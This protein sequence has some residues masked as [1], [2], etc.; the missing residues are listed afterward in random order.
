MAPMFLI[1]NVEMVV[2][3]LRAGITACLP[4]QNYRGPEKFEQAMLDIKNQSGDL[5]FG[6]NLIANRSNIQ[7]GEQLEVVLN[8]APKFIITSLGSPKEIITAAHKKNIMVFCDVVDRTHAEKVQSLG[9][10]AVVA[11]NSGA[12]GHAGNIPASILVP[13]LK[14]HLSLPVLSAGGVACGKSLHS[15]LALG[16]DGV[17]IG[18][19]FIA[20]IE[21]PVS[22]DYK[23]AIIDYGASDVVRTTKLSGTPCTVINTPYVKR[24]GTEQNSIERLLNNNRSLKKFTKMLTLYKGMKGLEKAAFSTTYKTVWCA[25]PSIE[26]VENIVTIEA[27]INTIIYDFKNSVKTFRDINL[28]K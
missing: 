2:A 24:V 27:L 9:A 14:K 13:S 16:A 6:V 23:K 7:L 22:E 17:S 1:T 5:P 15:V 28:D 25:G 19:P 21:S 10:D 18:T 12:G 8:A 26:L 4:A 3:A 20:T 11:V